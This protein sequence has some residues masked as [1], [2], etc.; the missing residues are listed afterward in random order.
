MR[1]WASFCIFLLLGIGQVRW[2]CVFGGEKLSFLVLDCPPMFLSVLGASSILPRLPWCIPQ[3]SSCVPDFP[4]V[5]G[6]CPAISIIMSIQILPLSRKRTWMS[7]S[8]HHNL[9]NHPLMSLNWSMIFPN[10]A[11]QVMQISCDLNA[12]NVRSWKHDV[13]SWNVPQYSSLSL[14]VH[15]MSCC[16][17]YIVLL[18]VYWCKTSL[19]VPFCPSLIPN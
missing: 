12:C 15:N 18:S 10:D 19:V 9:L 14:I 8:V 4:A 3:V 17:P 2:L 16:V 5:S 11:S 1:D 7:L 13:P 6:M